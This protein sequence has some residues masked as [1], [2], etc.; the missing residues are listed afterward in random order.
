MSNLTDQLADNAQ[1]ITV[2]GGGTM[3]IGGI[4][5][6]TIVAIIGGISVVIGLALQLVRSFRDKE[7]RA[8][9]RELHIIEMK[10]KIKQLAESK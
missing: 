1:F 4:S 2:G 7:R 9:E 5:A 8:E 3:F 10:I 6:S